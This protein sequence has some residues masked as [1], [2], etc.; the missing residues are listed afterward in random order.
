[1]FYR[2][3]SSRINF[4]FTYLIIIEKDLKK[5]QVQLIVELNVKNIRVFV[6]SSYQKH[7]ANETELTV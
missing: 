2:Y 1:M 5:L 7:Q 6:S 3:P 4:S